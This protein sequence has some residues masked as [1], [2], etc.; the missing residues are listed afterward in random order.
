MEAEE[1]LAAKERFWQDKVEEFIIAIQ[2]IE[3]RN[4]KDNVDM[5]T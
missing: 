3:K 5:A 1:A 4:Q 2:E